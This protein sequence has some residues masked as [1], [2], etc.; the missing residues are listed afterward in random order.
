MKQTTRRE[1]LTGGTMALLGGGFLSRVD[2]VAAMQSG[3]R[4]LTN[5]LKRQA[6]GSSEALMLKPDPAAEGP[7][8]PAD[9]D[10]L[11]LEWNKKTVRRFKDKL[12]EKDIQCFLVRDP[13]NIIYL[14]GR[15]HNYPLLRPRRRTRPRRLQ[16]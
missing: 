5:N 13:L 6:G 3:G 10:R 12:A 1:M 11:P 2:K 15:L 4:S 16:P 14:T 7:P 8:K 9:F